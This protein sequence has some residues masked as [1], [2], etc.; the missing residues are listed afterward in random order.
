MECGEEAEAVRPTDSEGCAR[1]LQIYWK[2]GIK[3]YSCFDAE[4][5]EIHVLFLDKR[6]FPQ[7]FEDS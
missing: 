3:W 1:G 2:S 6:H 5:V 7:V 4:N